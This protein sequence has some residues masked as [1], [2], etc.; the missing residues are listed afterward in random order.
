MGQMTL[1]PPPLQP[2]IDPIVL[3]NNSA[4]VLE[5]QLSYLS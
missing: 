3:P 5:I 2:V 4:H 1:L